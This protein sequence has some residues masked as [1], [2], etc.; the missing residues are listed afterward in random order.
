[1]KPDTNITIAISLEDRMAM[2]AFILADGSEKKRPSERAVRFSLLSKIEVPRKERRIYFKDLGN[3][4]ALADFHAIDAAAPLGITLNQLEQEDL[5]SLC[6]APAP[7][8]DMHW[9]RRIKAGLKAAQDAAA[10]AA[11]P[12]ATDQ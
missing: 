1:M 12:A 11:H 10:A 9:Q 4:S 2:E 3:G 7:I 6:D 5:E 8:S